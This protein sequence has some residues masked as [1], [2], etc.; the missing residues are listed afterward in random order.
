MEAGCQNEVSMN[1]DPDF[2]DD[3][4]PDDDESSAPR[5][6]FPYQMLL[7]VGLAVVVAGSLLAVLVLAFGS[8]KVTPTDKE[9]GSVPIVVTPPSKQDD[10]FTLKGPHLGSR[11]QNGNS[12]VTELPPA[13]SQT[14]TPS[15]PLPSA[16]GISVSG[17]ALQPPVDSIPLAAG[18]P[19][20]QWETGDGSVTG[21]A[22]FPEGQRALL[23]TGNSVRVLDLLSRKEKACFG[24]GSPLSAVAL[25]ADG[26]LALTGGGTVEDKNGQRTP[27][28]CTVRLWDV[29]KGRELRKLEGHTRPVTTVAVSSDGRW[30]LSA[31]GG[32][33]R[34]DN[35]AVVSIDSGIRLWNL[36]TY[37]QTLRLEGH[38]GGVRSVTFGHADQTC[39]SGGSDG[40][41]RVWNLP[42][43]DP[44]WVLRA[45]APVT[46]V[47]CATDGLHIVSG[48]T[49]GS[50]ILWSILTG[51]AM[52]RFEAPGQSKYVHWVGFMPDGRRLISTHGWIEPKAGKTV[53]VDPTVRC[54]DLTGTEDP[55]SFSDHTQ[56]VKAVAIAP[57]GNWLISAG[58]DRTV[59]LWRLPP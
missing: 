18:K 33:D 42:T 20:F 34:G 9:A 7:G 40:T 56:M 26:K 43:G 49:D 36:I 11:V 4:E 46:S 59:R 19:L 10:D 5:P 55:R 2:D 23:G 8:G 39:V 53:P 28:D 12:G 14:P 50:V 29:D 37:E 35:N 16:A 17:Q 6:S 47:A 32:E 44:R 1:A 13:G 58:Q 25:S 15:T 30:A 54:W 24:E 48:Q 38:K 52:R 27:R 21:L 41:V 31:G 22:L 45:G 3:E 51:E 57:Q